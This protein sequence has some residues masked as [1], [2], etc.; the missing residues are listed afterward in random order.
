M[1]QI[2]SF[3]GYA[4]FVLSKEIAKKHISEIVDLANQIPKVS[5]KT[6]KDILSEVKDDKVLYGKWKHSLIGFKGKDVFGIIIGYERRAEG[7]EQYPY[8]TI[9]INEFVVSKN[10]RK[11]GLGKKLL[12]SFIKN[13]SELGFLS[14]EGDLNFSVQTNSAKWNDYVMRLYESFGFQ[15]R[16]KKEYENRIDVVYGFTPE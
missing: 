12:E 3:N 8:N 15:E 6:E 11:K 5:H 4:V 13:S 10:Y 9:Y 14:L 16:A 1:R 2:E 7:N